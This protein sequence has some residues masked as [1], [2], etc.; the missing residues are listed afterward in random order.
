VELLC[1]G[2]KQTK[3]PKSERPQGLAILVRWMDTVKQVQ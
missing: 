1:D 3:L 2:D